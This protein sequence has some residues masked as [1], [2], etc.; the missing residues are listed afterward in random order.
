MIGVGD[1]AASLLGPD[2]YREHVLPYEIKLFEEIHNHGATVKLHICGNI[3]NIVGMMAQSGAD[4]LD[5]DS[6]VPLEHAR[7]QAGENITLCGN[8]APSEILLQGSPQDVAAAAKDCISK[9]DHRFF[10]MPGCEVPPATS[11]ENIRAFCPCMGSLV[12]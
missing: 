8:F 2:L 4:V 12:F 7:K 3:N 5:I 9:A 1:A 10:L 6:M 11:E